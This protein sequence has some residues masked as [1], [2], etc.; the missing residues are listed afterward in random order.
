M[1]DSSHQAEDLRLE[2]PVL[3]ASSFLPNGRHGHPG[4]GSLPPE[5]DLG[6]GFR[7]P[8]SAFG[9]PQR[10]WPSAAWAKVRVNSSRKADGREAD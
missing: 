2:F 10:V 6:W 4:R 7:T 8:H 9:I 1:A 5:G 3:H